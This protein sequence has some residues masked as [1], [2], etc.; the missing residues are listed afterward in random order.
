[1]KLLELYKE[2]CNDQT[3][4]ERYYSTSGSN[5][6]K[7]FFFINTNYRGILIKS[8]DK[9]Q[10]FANGF[11]VIEN[12][13]GKKRS[14]WLRREGTKQEIEKQHVVNMRKSELFR[15]VD[16]AYEK[17]S[18]GIVFKRLIDSKELTHEEKS[19]LCYL[20]ILTGYFNDVPNYI[21][22]RT[23]YVYKQWEKAGYDSTD[24]FTIQK[25]FVK[26]ALSA[27]HTYDIFKLDYIYLDSFFQ[28][29]DNLSFLSHYHNSS[30]TEKEELHNYIIL[31]Y[32]EKR[33]AN[34]KNDCVISYKFKPGGN[35]VKN[36]VIDNAWVLYVTKKIIDKADTDFDSFISTAISAYKELFKVDESKL[37][38]FIYNTDKN[39]SVFRVVFG[40][41][42]NVP[43]PVF[44]V[45]K[46]LT[47]Q[48]IEEYCT[49]DATEWEG[50]TKLDAVS[51]SLKKLAKIQASYRCALDECEI[52]KYFTAKDNG[53]N[54]LE[55]HHFIPKEF[56]N[57]FD[58]P[59]EVIE[60]YVALCPNCHRKIHLAIDSERKHMINIIFSLRQQLLAKKGLVVTLRDLYK[61]YKIDE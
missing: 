40:K 14:E 55:I 61:Y 41:A 58:Y 11:R 50:A 20:L 47:Q 25:E 46:D 29:L 9:L 4:F 56:A 28:E 21:I 16:D 39:H 38:S 42:T 54:Y 35:Y 53:K 27:E 18:R 37:R 1:M 15:V 8:G 52:C 13:E 57:D 44:A 24:C 5:F 22:E 45:A 3:F 48:E 12:V 23:K 59:I 49:S 30:K 34:K 43:I 10:G 33:F 32:K 17:T 26:A 7:V 31:N 51:S 60:N 6:G 19:F 2:L 36:T